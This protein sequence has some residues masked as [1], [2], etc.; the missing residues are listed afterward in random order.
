VLR[1]LDGKRAGEHDVLGTLASEATD[2]PGARPALDWIRSMLS[3]GD[4][5]ARARETVDRIALLAAAAALPDTE[6]ADL[7]AR[8]RLRHRQGSMFG[9]S[10]IGRDEG[11]RLLERALPA[12]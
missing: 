2:L 6:I 3:H 8:T 4:P 5:E 7:F 9:T 11:R 10:E 1:A 12:A